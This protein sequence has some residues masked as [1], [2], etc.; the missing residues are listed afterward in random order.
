MNIVEQVPLW[1]GGS[2]FRVYKQELY[3]WILR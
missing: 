2:M 1:Y 3:S